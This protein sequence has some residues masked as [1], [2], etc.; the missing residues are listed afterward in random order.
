M[1]W[2]TATVQAAQDAAAQ[3]DPTLRRDSWWRHYGCG[4]V[5]GGRC[6]RCGARLGTRPPRP[7]LA[8]ESVA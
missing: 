3:R 5:R 8:R 6:Q 4:N 2:T 7:D 1:P